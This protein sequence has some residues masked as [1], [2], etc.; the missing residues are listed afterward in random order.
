MGIYP[1]T[2]YQGGM[3]R[4][5]FIDD[6]MIIGYVNNDPTFGSYWNTMADFGRDGST[7]VH[8]FEKAWAKVNGSYNSIVSGDP[9]EVLGIFTG[10]PSKQW[11]KGTGY[12]NSYADY[13]VLKPALIAALSR[14]HSVSIG[15]PGISDSNKTVN[16]LAANHAY[17]V[18][19]YYNCG[20]VDL[21]R[22]RNPWRKE[23]F[24][25][26]YSDSNVSWTAALKTCVGSDYVVDNDGM[27]FI[28]ANVM[29]VDVNSYTIVT[30]EFDYKFSYF[31]L[32]DTTH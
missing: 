1:F 25:G 6:R 15:T 17:Q 18:L 29:D 20:G 4:R 26:V 3:P 27:F 12:S 16:G 14:G 5:F 13:S 22:I 32:D 2:W 19:A 10:A 21:W 7:W 31:E 8:L 23:E 11:V 9:G 30:I 24:T 28:S